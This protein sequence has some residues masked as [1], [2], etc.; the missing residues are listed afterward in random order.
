MSKDV[1]KAKNTSRLLTRVKTLEKSNRSLRRKNK[2]LQ[3]ATFID[4]I[5]DEISK[6]SLVV[7][8][9]TTIFNA[10]SKIRFIK[11]ILKKDE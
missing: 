11:Q 4:E 10:C 7:Q 5:S 8:T 2:E 6:I 1:E 9:K 3:K